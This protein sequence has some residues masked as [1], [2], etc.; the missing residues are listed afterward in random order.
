M[1]DEKVKKTNPFIRYLGNRLGLVSREEIEDFMKKATGVTS[2]N[3][4]MQ[5]SSFMIGQAIPPDMKAEEYLKAFRG[6]VF[7]CVSA[8]AQETASMKLNLYK[9]KSQNEFEQVDNHPALD[10]LYKVNPLYTSYLLWEATQAYLELSGESFWWLVGPTPSPRE[11]WTLRPDWVSIKD[12][13]DRIIKSYVY[14]PPGTPIDKKIEIPF[15]QMIHFKDFNPLNAYRGFGATKAGAKSIDE[16]DFQQDYSRNFFY[17]SALPGGALETDKNLTDDQYD[18]VKSSWEETHRGSK[19]AWKVAILEAGLKW[20]DIGMNRRDMDF[21]EGRRLTRDEILM[22]YRV[23]KAII[24]VNDDVNRAASRESRAIFLENNITHKMKRLVSFLNEFLLPRYG[25]DSLFFDFENPVPNDETAKLA[26]YDNGLRH[27]WLTRNEVRELEDRD[28]IEGGDKLMIPFSLQDIGASLD[29]QAQ[30]EQAKKMREK[31]MKRFNVRIPTYPYIKARMDEVQK[32]IE[33][34]AENL[35]RSMIAKKKVVNK[36]STKNAEE[37]EI[38]QEDAREAHWKTLIT[39]TD[40]REIKYLH[41]LNELF[42]NQ[43]GEVKD[44][45]QNELERV[46]KLGK[47]K[48][49]PASIADGVIKDTDVFANVLMDFVKTVIEA[50]G[51]QVIQSIVD[52]GIFFMQTPAI[53]KYLKK[54]GVKFLASINEETADQLRDS[55]AEGIGKQESIPQLK[56]RVSVIYEDARGFRA[57]RIA[58]SEVLRATNFATEQAYR[59][60]KVVEKKEWLTAKDERTCPW[61]APMDGKTL[62]LNGAFYEEGD[63]AVGTNDKGKKVYLKIN[64]ADVKY[65]PLHPNCRCTLIPVISSDEKSVDPNRKTLLLQRL[66]DDTLEEIRENLNN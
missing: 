59:Q 39:R 19:K 46:A 27:G 1:S 52:Q 58:R 4:P 14:G 28:P 65:P 7:A 11:I 35:I 12:T 8:I 2:Q 9:R 5:R 57:T 29:Q 18:R 49:S 63:T 24:A 48:A 40:P 3:R 42:T 64:V 23:P 13:Q 15:E 31:A 37:G 26:L 51:I 20:Q 33:I 53:Q 38:V 30:E 34:V 47:T 45:V 61:C 54:D 10:L 25:D 66:T 21:V 50:E 22:I 62:D 17:N 41:L 56:E 16:N 36:L 55:L 32:Q 6:T 44:A 60:S 43:E